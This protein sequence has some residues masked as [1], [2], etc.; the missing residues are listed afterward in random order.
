MAVF[1]IMLRKVIKGSIPGFS[2]LET[3]L[4]LSILG[5]ISAGGLSLLNKSI[6]HRKFQKTEDNFQEIIHALTSF[7]IS[8]HRLPCPCKWENREIGLENS[9]CSLTND[10]QGVI[11]FRSL[12][13]SSEYTKNGDNQWITYVVNPS[14]T[15]LQLRYLNTEDET[16]P[17]KKVFCELKS[18]PLPFSL[19][20]GKTQNILDSTKGTFAFLILSEKERK[21]NPPYTIFYDVKKK[22]YK[23]FWT[24]REQFL[25]K[26]IRMPCFPRKE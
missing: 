22:G 14:L 2:L 19:K 1:I 25:A 3:A 16:V 6:Q 11:P 21:Q 24:T 23:I 9:D 18:M 12:G 10:Y 7:L 4:S 15:S 8:H 20:D 17:N 5:I 13:I 26:F